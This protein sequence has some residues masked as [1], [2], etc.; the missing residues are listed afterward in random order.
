MT[1]TVS[2]LWAHWEPQQVRPVGQQEMGIVLGSN[3]GHPGPV[4]AYTAEPLFLI[5]KPGAQDTYLSWLPW[6]LDHW[7][8]SYPMMSI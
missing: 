7:G 8:H 5:C 4:D 2:L 1:F 3:P 6:G